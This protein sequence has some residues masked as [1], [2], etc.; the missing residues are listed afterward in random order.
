MH[1]RFDPAVEVAVGYVVGRVVGQRGRLNLAASLREGQQLTGFP[2]EFGIPLADD[3]DDARHAEVHLV[4]RSHGQ[5]IP[6]LVDEMLH[7][8]NAGCVY[9]GP[10]EGSEPDYGTEGPNTCEDRYFAV[11]PTSEH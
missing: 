9:S 7:T 4:L 1:G 11:F 10:I 8:F 6:G 5:K 3:L 2:T